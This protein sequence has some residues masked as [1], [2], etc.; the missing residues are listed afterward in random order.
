LETGLQQRPCPKGINVGIQTL[1]LSLALQKWGVKF[2]HP[3]IISVVL[4]IIHTSTMSSLEN[5]LEKHKYKYT[6]NDLTGK[7]KKK[8]PNIGTI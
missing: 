2:D 3:I 7:E 4:Y 5:T 1:I 8:A 6:V